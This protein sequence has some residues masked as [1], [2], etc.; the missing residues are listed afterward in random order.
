MHLRKKQYVAKYKK[1]ILDVLKDVD[2]V[3]PIMHGVGGEDGSIQWFLKTVHIPFVGAD[4]L[5]S[6]VCLD[7]ALCKMVLHSVMI[8]QMPYVVLDYRLM[9][10]KSIAEGL[11]NCRNL[12]LPLFVKPSWLGSSVGI[13][14]VTD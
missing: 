14:K 7:K 8:P 13:S 2:V 11:R 10:E 12:K 3:F 5:A 1:N 9:P 6:A 4:V